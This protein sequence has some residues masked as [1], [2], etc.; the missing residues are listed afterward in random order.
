MFMEQ[1]KI[2]KGVIGFINLAKQRKVHKMS[3][4]LKLADLH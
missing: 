1:K 2:G 3:L 4:C